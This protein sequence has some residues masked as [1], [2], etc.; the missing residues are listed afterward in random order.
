MPVRQRLRKYFSRKNDASTPDE[1]AQ[2]DHQEQASASS[3]S[4]TTTNVQ[5]PTSLP[6]RLWDQAYNDLKTHDAALSQAYEKILSRKLGGQGFNSPVTKSEQNIIAQDDAHTRRAQMR[7]LIHDGLDKTAQEA[8][9]K[10]SIGTA[11]Q[12]VLSVE[13]IISSAVQ[14]VPQAALTWAAATEANRSGI[15]YVIKRMDWY[16]KLSSIVLKENLTDS[17]LSDVRCEMETRVIDLYKALLSYEIKSVCSY[18]RN[19]GLV[20]LREIAKL[21]D[22]NGNMQAIQD[23]EHSFHDDSNT[24]AGLK[25]ISNLEQLVTHAEM[26][27]TA[28]ITKED[29][30]FEQTKGGLLQESYRWILDNPG[31]QEWR[32]SKESRL[33]WIKGDPGKGKTML[34]CG[35][36]NE[37]N[38]QSVHSG[39]ASYF[40]CQATDQQLN[41]AVA[42]LRGLIFMF[43]NKQPS[44]ISHLREKYDQVGG[45]LFEGPN[46]WIALSDVFMAILQD[47]AL[48]ST[49]LIID[50]LDECISDLQKL[51]DFIVDTSSTDIRVKWIVSSRN[52]S[53]IEERLRRAERNVK[54]S[55]ELNAESISH[56]VHIYIQ[57]KVHQLADLKGYDN[58]TCNVVRNYLFENAND[59]FL[60]VALVCQ[61]LEKYQWWNVIKILEAFPPGLDSLYKQM[62]EQVLGMEDDSNISLCKQI[63]AVMT[64][65]YRPVSLRELGCLIDIPE[66][67]ANNVKFLEGIV[68]F[69]GSFLTIR[70]DIIYFVH[71]SAKDHLT[72]NEQAILAIFPSGCGAVHYAIFYHSLQAMDK[73]LGKNIYR[74]SY[75]GSF[76][77]GGISIPDPDPLRAIRYSCIHWVGHLCE[78]IANR[79]SVGHCNDLGDDGVVS[80][81]IQRHLLHW[82]ES[83]GLLQHVPDGVISIIKLVALLMEQSPRG[84]LLNFFQDAHRFILYNKRAIEVAP[85]QTYLSALVFSPMQSL[86]RKTFHQDIPAWMHD[87]PIVEDQWSPCLQTLETS[88]RPVRS[89]AYLNNNQI[90]AASD[91]TK[92]KIWDI[93][94]GTCVQ[95]LEDYTEAMFVTSLSNGRIAS[96]SYSGTIKIWDL[97]TSRCVQTIESQ[98]DEVSSIAYLIDGS[99]V[100]GSCD[101]TIK[102]WDITTGACIQTLKGHT[103][104][105]YS[106][107]SSADGQ[108]ASGSSGGTI[109]IWDVATGACTQVLEGHSSYITDMM[110]LIDSQLA[111][112]SYDGTIKI[113][114]IAGKV[115]TQTPQN[116]TK[117]VYSIAI[118]GDGHIASGSKDCTIRIWDIST[119][120]CLRVLKGHDDSI[121]SVTFSEDSQQIASSSFDR[122]VKI[123]DVATGLCVRSLDARGSCRSVVFSADR[124]QVAGSLSATVQI[125][126]IATGTLVHALRRIASEVASMAF[127]S[128]SRYIASESFDKTV[129]IWDTATGRRVHTLE[130]H[131]KSVISIAFSSDSRYIASGSLDETVNIWDLATGACIQTI[132][133]VGE[134]CHLSFD[135]K[136]N[137]RLY[138]NLG[139][140]DLD[141][142]PVTGVLPTQRSSHQTG[143]HG[144]GIDRNKEWIVKDGKPMLWLP[145][146]YRLGDCAVVG[147]TVIIGCGSGLG[148]VLILRFSEAGPD[149]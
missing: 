15:E 82:L 65:V 67:L 49:Y 81:F 30:Q 36:I 133:D 70:G 16:W 45:K 139:A 120:R 112:A 85:L 83:L 34:L 111:S 18:Y 90:A 4:A 23:A 92:L 66:E 87:R 53:Q 60:W 25:M 142:A 125:W 78:G 68:A 55:L 124:R 11:T 137:S 95:I 147:S 128:D 149:S 108:I 32:D 110:F 103:D 40:F 37:L 8:K 46:T 73:A 56:A 22:W 138:T 89:L 98:Y 5:A 52:W 99:I 79:I 119:G 94:T 126:D 144:Y 41:N 26:Q 42:V 100:L 80:L 62:M 107:T 44:L 71:Q 12:L 3:L 69:C 131:T 43:V 20:L 127:S 54:L 9:I 28:Q 50:A 84:Q 58:E 132:N 64:S 74:L 63:L 129:K 14:A 109:K 101:S 35:I 114:D 31:Y 76:L 113:W 6:E 38:Q 96:V 48:K 17:S 72:N 27:S 91:A 115:G 88:E 51:L 86:I 10:E 77:N 146:E 29:Q 57:Q 121:V 93:T 47:P 116:H 21:D 134:A 97:A 75:F 148:R 7:Q 145:Q 24:F 19:R 39:T 13:D 135:A 33:L 141:L 105:V 123:W 130:G 136:T 106:L 143:L 59:T 61:N 2:D 102:I 122:M 1:V 118:S 117:A 104:S 140:L